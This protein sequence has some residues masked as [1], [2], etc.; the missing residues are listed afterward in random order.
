MSPMSPIQQSHSLSPSD[1]MHNSMDSMDVPMNQAQ[2]DAMIAANQQQQHQQQQ[3]Q[4]QQQYRR[5][6]NIIPIVHEEQEIY[7]SDNGYR[8]DT[9][10]VHSPGS[11]PH[12]PQDSRQELSHVLLHDVS[13]NEFNQNAM[14]KSLLASEA[15]YMS[16]SE[17]NGFRVNNLKT[18]PEGSG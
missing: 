3:Q 15:F 1:H 7:R 8:S 13:M 9:M 14:R 5:N 18:E 10:H 4:D 11:M 17:I 6:T 2:Y 16:T 12:S